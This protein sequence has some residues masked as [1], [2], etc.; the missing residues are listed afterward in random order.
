MNEACALA[1]YYY[2]Q[3]SDREARDQ[4]HRSNAEE[5]KNDEHPPADLT[6]G[7]LQIIEH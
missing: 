5:R 6:P 2:I 7:V 1:P 3:N 4:K